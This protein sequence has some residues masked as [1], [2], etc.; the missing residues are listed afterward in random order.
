M[1]PIMHKFQFLGV[2]HQIWHNFNL[3]LLGNR[4][5]LNWTLASCYSASTAV[6]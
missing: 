6:V 1:V 3:P 5:N 4:S 2:A